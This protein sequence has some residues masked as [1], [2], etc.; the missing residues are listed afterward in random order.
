MFYFYLAETV[1]A[2]SPAKDSLRGT[3][4]ET[5]RDGSYKGPLTFDPHSQG[6]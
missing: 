5:Q 4:S 2:A 3:V 1:A 6:T